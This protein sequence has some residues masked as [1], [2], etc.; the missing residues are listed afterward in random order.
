MNTINPSMLRP[1][2]IAIV[3]LLAAGGAARAAEKEAPIDWPARAATVKVG[4]TRAEVEKILPPP[5]RQLS[6]CFGVSAGYLRIHPVSND[7][8]VWVFYWQDPDGPDGLNARV[9]A[10]ATIHAPFNAP[11][12]SLTVNGDAYFPSDFS[13]LTIPSGPVIV[14]FTSFPLD[15]NKAP[16][17]FSANWLLTPAYRFRPLGSTTQSSTRDSAGH[18][19]SNQF[20]VTAAVAGMLAAGGV[21]RAAEKE[22][23]IDWPARAA[24][25]K[26]GMT[27][28]EVEK[29]LPRWTLP[30][31][32]YLSAWVGE[33][34]VVGGRFSRSESYFVA[35]GWL[36]AVSYDYASRESSTNSAGRL[37]TQGAAFEPQLTL[38]KLEDLHGPWNRLREPV[39]VQKIKRSSDEK[40]DWPARAATVKVGMTRAEVEKI[41]PKLQHPRGSTV[42]YGSITMTDSWNAAV[43]WVSQDWRVTVK[44]DY[45][46]AV[47]PVTATT[48]QACVGPANRV[49]EPV[50]TLRIPLPPEDDPTLYDAKLSKQIDVILRECRTIKPGMTRADLLK[51]FTTE[52]GLSSPEAR[53]YVNRRCYF[54]KVDVEFSLTDPNQRTDMLDHERPT[55]VITKISKPYLEWNHLD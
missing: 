7:C 23:P 18:K 8:E 27:R 19:P 34:Q 25:V 39:K 46:G 51:V 11:L 17:Y 50:K 16:F 20:I 3:I 14:P 12:R 33:V 44:Y 42:S 6:N 47:K 5:N 22:A 53:T 26:V 37:P 21:A 29:I 2:I 35:D 1:A 9:S 55:D 40:I 48:M 41:L 31:S 43:Y 45:S 36:A 24:T 10:P 32:S 13:K 38:S 28:A 52:G 4:M 15:E 49:I 30:K 54:I